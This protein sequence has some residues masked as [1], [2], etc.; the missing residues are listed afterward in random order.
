M[1]RKLVVIGILVVALVA[2]FTQITIA[3]SGVY[4]VKNGEEIPVEDYLTHAEE[5][6]KLPQLLVLSTFLGAL[7][8]VFGST[9]L[10]WYIKWRQD[11][12]VFEYSY[13][14]SAVLSGFVIAL[15]MIQGMPPATPI[16][17]A[18]VLAFLSASGIKKIGDAPLDT[19]RKKRAGT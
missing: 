2:L 14:Y 17:L 16:W 18:G 3:D 11:K 6:A 8:G 19:M 13:L 10:P 1:E 7:I 15:T 5:I 12:R 4:I 9:I